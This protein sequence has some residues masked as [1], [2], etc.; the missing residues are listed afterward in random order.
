[1]TRGFGSLLVH[2]VDGVMDLI[3]E[4]V[5]RSEGSVGQMVAFEI[6]PASLDVIEFGRV[7]GQPLDG[8]PGSGGERLG[9]EFAGVDRTV[10]EHDHRRLGTRPGMG[11]VSP[12]QRFQQLDEVGASLG[13]AG[14]D[15]Q[16]VAGRVERTQHRAL[17]GL[18]RRLNPDIG[19]PSRPNMGEVGMG[20]RLGFILEEEPDVARLGL[21]AQEVQPDARA[22]DGLVVLAPLERVPG[23]APGEAPF[24]R[25]MMLSRETEMVMPHRRSISAFRR[26][27]VQSVSPGSDRMVVAQA[28]AAAPFAPGRPVRRRARSASTPPDTKTCRSRRTP[29]ARM[30]IVRPII[31]PV[32]PSRL[33]SIE[34]ARSASRRSDDRASRSSAARSSALAVK[35]HLPPRIRVPPTQID[36]AILYPWEQFVNPA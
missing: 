27:N 33:Q 21:L 16:F 25:S 34:R 13:P 28:S 22:L 9:A 36:N 5:E 26:G 19:S 4:V 29:S 24:L 6:A 12:V 7:L 30:P 20:E 31:S 2:V 14:D 32:C 18:S 15:D 10:V 11:S 8:E 23:P 17:L 3:V 1:M 35:A